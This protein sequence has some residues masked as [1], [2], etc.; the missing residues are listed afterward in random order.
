ML[1]L[2]L[3][4][5][6]ATPEPTATIRAGETRM[7]AIPV[8][9]IAA[10]PSPLPLD[11]ATNPFFE[12]LGSA[13]I[14]LPANRVFVRI[15]GLAAGSS[16]LTV[17]PTSTLITVTPDTAFT[18]PATIFAPSE[19]ASIWGTIAIGVEA[20]D[21]PALASIELEIAA[22]RQTTPPTP[23]QIIASASISAH[24][25]GP[26]RAATFDLNSE[27]LESDRVTLTPVCIF[28]DGTRG[29]GTPTTLNVIRPTES[30]LTVL[31]AETRYPAQRPKRFEDTKL[32]VGMDAAASE[33]QFLANYSAEPAM[34]APLH[35]ETA[36]WY[37]V[38]GTF[39]GSAAA[40]TLPTV[41]LVVD[42][43]PYGVTN[44]RI[45]RDSWHRVPLG[46][47]VRLE[48]GERILTPYFET[49]FYV[50]RMADRNLKI[51]RIEVV[52]V[53]DAGGPA[54]SASGM[55]AGG[56]A[57]LAPTMMSG[58]MSAGSGAA[59]VDDPWGFSS[60]PL[61]VAFDRAFDGQI[62]PGDVRIMGR[63]WWPE[64][65]MV[66][67]T[68]RPK[69]PVVSLLINGEEHSRQSSAAPIFEPDSSAWKPGRNTVQLVARATT[70]EFART[71]EQIVHWSGPVADVETPTFVRFGPR[72][73]AW[74]DD[75]RSSL[76]K[77]EN[78]ER[79]GFKLNSPTVIEV[80][81]P[82]SLAGRFLILLEA[83][84]EDFMGLPVAKVALV[85]GDTVT[86]IKD[87]EIP[88]WWD[89]HESGEVDL[90][91]GPKSLRFTFLNDRFQIAVGDRNLAVQ[92]VSLRRRPAGADV[93]PPVVRV[94]YPAPD[95]TWTGHMADAVVIETADDRT[96]VEAELIIDGVQT[97]QTRW[98]P[99]EFGRVVLP[100]LGRTMEP[101]PHTVAI[102][103]RDDAGNTTTSADFT[104]HRLAEPATVPTRYQR[105]VRLLN[106]FA[107]G[108][109]ER[110]LA[111]LLALGEERWLLERLITVPEEAGDLV[112]IG[113]GLT[114]FRNPRSEYEV[115]GR[116][117]QQA[118]GTTNPVRMRFTLWAQNHFSTWVNKTEGERKWTEHVTFSRLGVAPFSELLFASATG[119]AMLR[120]LDQDTSYAG[121]INEN[122]AREIMELHTLGVSGGYT[123]SDVT[124][125]AHLLTG[126]TSA[127]I[128]DGRSGGEIR[129][130]SFR[131]DPAL[132]EGGATSLLGYP[133]AKTERAGRYDRVRAALDLLAAHP[134]S[135]HFVCGKL[136]AHYTHSPPDESLV[137]DLAVVFEATGGDLREVLLA[138]AAHPEF[139]RSEA[140]LAHPLDYALRLMRV[141]NTDNAWTAIDFL[142]RSGAGIFDRATP[143]GY[144]Q[145]DADYA[146]SNALIQRWALAHELR[147]GISNLAFPRLR[148]G[149]ATEDSQWAQN[150]IDSAAIRLTGN[151]LGESSNHAIL[152]AAQ[153]GDGTPHDRCRAIAEL[154]AQMPECNLK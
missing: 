106:R 144:S 40:G 87:A 126:W 47:P 77:M 79:C 51:D 119:P 105:A 17:G 132:A 62:V 15:R 147:W 61:R 29:R 83:R 27:T 80:A 100:V 19:G 81:L 5:A 88:T 89:G 44:T 102:R 57:S 31:E 22:E 73:P 96:V 49:D 142:Q 18:Q 37:Q 92:G 56:M 118:L 110:E 74:T 117:L 59:A 146:D 39:G 113:R 135:A 20:H 43:A 55:M 41:S 6:L 26:L 68:P 72:D 58:A 127:Q 143:D 75:S 46:V 13:H 65:E 94:V 71:P 25:W 82:E 66:K 139:F 125:L 76:A 122:Y 42:G 151:V 10:L 149:N 129:L 4:L 152:V 45:V 21:S 86:H 36:G 78:D 90:V 38:I 85:V 24:G 130:H 53:A 52:R 23:P 28:A 91:S 11:P 112:A 136:A 123:Q 2:L 35:V 140:R 12:V 63:A 114:D 50:E 145:D 1:T 48:P 64:I 32:S 93:T 99:R 108:P 54:D 137:A 133:F 101:G 3:A 95:E 14:S 134:R 121:R 150:V 98:M 154:V 111:L 103:T 7:L 131:F 153:T 124:A 30:G 16:P 69:C 115:K 34:C 84:G 8:A 60:M 141:T 33:G 107:L 148:W 116:A 128:G 109:D 67:Q 120:Y 9:E 97:G 104:F 70:G 138:L